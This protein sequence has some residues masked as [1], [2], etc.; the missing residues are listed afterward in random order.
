MTNL[1]EKSL[2]QMWIELSLEENRKVE[3]ENLINELKFQIGLKIGFNSS[4]SRALAPRF[5]GYRPVV[6][7]NSTQTTSPEMNNSSTYACLSVNNFGQGTNIKNL[8]LFCNT[9]FEIPIIFRTKN[10]EKIILTPFVSKNFRYGKLKEMSS[11]ND[12]EP[13]AALV[14][15]FRII[16]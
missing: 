5:V 3:I 10:P 8:T 9:E 12:S 4:F 2:K 13:M 15:N 6:T 11:F 7:E 14:F 16:D 1:V